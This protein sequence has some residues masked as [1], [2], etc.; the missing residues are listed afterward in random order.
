MIRSSLNLTDSSFLNDI[1]N[2]PYKISEL[3]FDNISKIFKTAKNIFDEE[4]LLLEFNIKENV[5][6]VY[7]IGDIHGNLNTLMKLIDIINKNSP[8][9]VIFLGDIVDRGSKQLECLLIVLILK[10]LFPLKYCRNI[11]LVHIGPPLPLLENP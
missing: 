7:V 1:I 5:E 3:E 9:L 4:Y 10:I 2:N 8:K 6:E 11:P